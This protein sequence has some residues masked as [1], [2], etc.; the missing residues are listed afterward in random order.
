MKLEFVRGSFTY[1]SIFTESGMMHTSIEHLPLGVISL[2]HI[3]SVPGR[4]ACSLLSLPDCSQVAS[5]V[6]A[7]VGVDYERCFV[8][9]EIEDGQD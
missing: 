1:V 3:A 7:V 2:F 4:G 8:K 9:L 6:G 5:S